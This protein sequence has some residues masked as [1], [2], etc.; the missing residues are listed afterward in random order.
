ML[1]IQVL[2]HVRTEKKETEVHML[3][4][5]AAQV[6]SLHYVNELLQGSSPSSRPGSLDSWNNTHDVYE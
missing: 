5:L 6:G 4:L 2:F 1:R 3:K